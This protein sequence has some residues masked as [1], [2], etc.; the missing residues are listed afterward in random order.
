MD[1]FKTDTMSDRTRREY[2]EELGAVTTL[3]AA[4]GCLDGGDSSG[5]T[6]END[7]DTATTEQE[8]E[9]EPDGDQSEADDGEETQNGS[10]ENTILDFVPT[11]EE[12]N[13]EAYDGNGGVQLLAIGFPSD[14]AEII[15]QET[16]GSYEENESFVPYDFAN[17]SMSQVDQ[18]AAVRFEGIGVVPV[19]EFAEDITQDLNE[20]L[21]QVGEYR[22]FDVMYLED[23]GQPFSDSTTDRLILYDGNHALRLDVP[24]ND[25]QY[26]RTLESM[27]DASNDETLRM[28]ENTELGQAL[29]QTDYKD[30]TQVGTQRIDSGLVAAGSRFDFS[31][32]SYELERIELDEQGNV[33]V[34]ES[35]S[36]GLGEYNSQI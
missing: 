25:D 34:T 33:N 1:L 26:Q 7:T 30:V 9:G 21:Q 18:K 20:D 28:M 31:E 35:N 23:G 12:L 11:S 24:E 36:F 13:T 22:G 17:V 10:T 6:T 8:T 19:Y 2:L 29:A 4:A 14:V 32:D 16:Q 3:G 27:V 15:P 5:T